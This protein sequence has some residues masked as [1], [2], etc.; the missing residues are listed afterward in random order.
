MKEQRKNLRYETLATV[1]IKEIGKEDFP[2]KDLSITGC[3]IEFP[4]N[5]DI[6]PNM[7]F[8]LK[9]IPENAAEVEPF[10]INTESRWVSVSGRGC[11]AG[12]SLVEPPK[13]KQF[14]RYVDYLSWRWSQG[15]S[16]TNTNV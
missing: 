3:R 13:G 5:K 11:E 6:M 16:M 12:F 10:T 9:I 1:K 4:I 7:R 2:L 14:Q 8:S 15:Q